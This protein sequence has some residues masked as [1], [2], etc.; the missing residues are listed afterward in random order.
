MSGIASPAPLLSKGARREDTSVKRVEQTRAK[1]RQVNETWFKG[2]WT[3][4]ERFWAAWR[5]A[6]GS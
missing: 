2:G 1:T 4:S 5:R 3:W 6:F